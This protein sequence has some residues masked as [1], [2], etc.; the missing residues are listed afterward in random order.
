VHWYV[1]VLKKYAVFRGRARRREFWLYTLVNIVV[2][3]VLEVVDRVAGTDG[4]FPVISGIYGLLVLLPTLAVTIRR[5][6]DT[7]RSGWWIL[8]NLIPVIGWLVVLV[9][10]VMD[11][12]PGPNRHGDDPKHPER[13]APAV[14]QV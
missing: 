14:P 1:A 4:H 7:D 11:G 3:L 13:P 12:T 2:S 10:N 8:L 5:L 9:F 6:H